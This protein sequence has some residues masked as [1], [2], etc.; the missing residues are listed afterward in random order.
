MEPL[1]LTAAAAVV[2]G[3]IIG[4]MAT[5]RVPLVAGLMVVL[6]L[7][8]LCGREYPTSAGS[9]LA[10]GGQL[11][12]TFL[13]GL[14][15]WIGLRPT[16]PRLTPTL[17]PGALGWALLAAFAAIVGIAGWPVLVE[18][19]DPRRLGEA[20]AAGSFDP[21]RWTLGAGLA[22]GV[23]AARQ[24]VAPEPSR[25]AA[26]AA[27]AAAAAWLIGVAAGSSASDLGLVVT[28]LVLPIAGSAAAW[29]SAQ[30]A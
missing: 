1:A 22:A 8:P 17:W 18:A 14:V 25:F 7:L 12:A 26:G 16:G 11:A 29:R 9:A 20:L 30:A 19:L 10:A 24:L 4:A 21:M 5:R 27:F 13:G 15:L 28:A 6:I 23:A 3:A 2:G